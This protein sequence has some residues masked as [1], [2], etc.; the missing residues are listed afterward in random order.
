M[1][2]LDWIF[3]AVLLISLLLGIWRGLIYEVFSVLSWFAA[4]ILAQWF[5]PQVAAKLPMA[6]AAEAVRYAAGFAVVFV[7]AVLLG[8]LIAVLA[9]KLFAAIGLQPVDRTL[10]AAFGLVRGVVLLMAATVVINMT[11]LRS[12]PWW[13]AS[14]SA[15]VGLAMLKGLKPILPQEFGKYLPS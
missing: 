5:A 4:F 11:A 10:G 6:G 14:A 12:E 1:P 2:A 3:A 8:G 9:K 7:L 13:Q 15:G